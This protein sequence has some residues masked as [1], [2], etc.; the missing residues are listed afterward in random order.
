MKGKEN[1][2]HTAQERLKEWFLKGVRWWGGAET[3]R[4]GI[5]DAGR[6]LKKRELFYHLLSSVRWRVT[7]EKGL[8]KFRKN[9]GRRRLWPRTN[10]A[11]GTGMN[12]AK[13]RVGIV[14]G[15]PEDR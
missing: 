9:V 12:E 5:E 13:D 2:G 14:I 1:Q 7:M 10:T 4:K 15:R 6:V 8:C 11:G 3:R